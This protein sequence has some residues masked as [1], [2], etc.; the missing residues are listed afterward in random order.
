[1]QAWREIRPWLCLGL[2]GLLA[3][4]FT[5]WGLMGSKR[6]TLI[7][8]PLL[9]AMAGYE[10]WAKWRRVRYS[11]LA[12]AEAEEKVGERLAVLE[13]RGWQVLHGVMKPG[14]N[15]SD[16][17]H[18]VWGPRG[19]FV[20]ETKAHRGKV[21]VEAGVLT[22]DGRMPERDP[23]NQVVHNTLFVKDHLKQELRR[24]YWVV[25]VV[26][27]TEAFIP[28]YRVDI[29]RRKVH[30]IK[31]ER[32]IDFLETYDDTRPLRRDQIQQIADAM[33]QILPEG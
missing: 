15:D 20:I 13:K 2:A 8:I 17:D 28:D 30:V 5:V 9:L 23:V 14:G 4:Y 29:P 31:V 3:I 1:M 19:I 32:L 27:L 25:S 6:F 10:F 12:G 33:L 18:I 21:G 26:C 16:I 24:E 22:F 7:V 11:W